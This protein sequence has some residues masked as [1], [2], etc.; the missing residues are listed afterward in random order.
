MKIIFI[1]SLSSATPFLFYMQHFLPPI[2]SLTWCRYLLQWNFSCQIHLLLSYMQRDSPDS[3]EQKWEL[4]AEANK[5]PWNSANERR[6]EH[7]SELNFDC[8]DRN[9]GKRKSVNF[10]IPAGGQLPNRDGTWC[11]RTLCQRGGIDLINSALTMPW[12]I[13]SE[14]HPS[15]VRYK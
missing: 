14:Y 8:A 10:S 13:M 4:S 6:K 11:G 1:L 3:D 5:V 12:D 15:S 7:E 2:S 9:T